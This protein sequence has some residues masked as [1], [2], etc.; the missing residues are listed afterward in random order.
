MKNVTHKEILEF[1]YDSK[2]ERDGHVKE[3]LLQ[4]WGNSGQHKRMKPD[5]SVW[6]SKDEDSYEWFADFW[7]YY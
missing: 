2:E 7:K 4:G 5:K 1:T 6:D 3:M